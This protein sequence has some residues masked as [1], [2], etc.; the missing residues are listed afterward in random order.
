MRRSAIQIR[1]EILKL[2]SKNKELSLRHLD[3]KINTSSE[4]IRNQVKDLES[5]GFVIIKEYKSHPQ[6]KKPYKA[7]MIT[8]DG[9]KWIKK[10][11]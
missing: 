4:T 10:E 1:K 11:R 8:A 2:L 5:L 6:N 3:V 9:L 7:C